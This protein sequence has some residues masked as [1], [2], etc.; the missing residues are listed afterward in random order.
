M[1]I[2]GAEIKRRRVKREPANATTDVRPKKI[3][4]IVYIVFI[5]TA[6]ILGIFATIS[7][8]STK[9][10]NNYASLAFV[11]CQEFVRDR[12]KSPSSSDFPFADYTS[13]RVGDDKYIIKSYVDAQ[14]TFGA[15]IRSDWKCEILYTGNTSGSREWELLNLE[16]AHR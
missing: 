12:L 8:P 6:F 2:D 3:K 5:A 11:Q 4:E 14:N 9:K 13:W 1:G 16:F 10:K 15:M 7:K